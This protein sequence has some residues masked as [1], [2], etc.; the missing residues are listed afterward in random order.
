MQDSA[1]FTYET[2]QRLLE[3]GQYRQFCGFMAVACVGGW[4]VAENFMHASPVAFFI[5]LL[6]F[7]F[8][9]WRF[10]SMKSY[11]EEL[12]DDVEKAQSDED[13][14]LYR[15]LL[16]QALGKSILSILFLR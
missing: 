2:S 7:A 6:G 5:G 10:G 13:R 14:K 11:I 16:H 15:D 3:L 1:T 4:F 8:C 12:S 9:W